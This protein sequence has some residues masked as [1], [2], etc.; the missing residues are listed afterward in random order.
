MESTNGQVNIDWLTAFKG[1]DGALI[2]LSEARRELRRARR[3]SHAGLAAERVAGAFARVRE[4]TNAARSAVESD[5]GPYSL[6]LLGFVALKRPAPPRKGASMREVRA[7]QIAAKNFD[8]R[9]PAR[10]TQEW[11]M[12]YL[13]LEARAAQ[14]LVEHVEHIG[15]S[16]VLEGK[17]QA[18]VIETKRRL[19]GLCCQVKIIESVRSPSESEVKRSSREPIAEAVRH[20]VWRRDDGRCVDCG[21]RERLEYDHIIPVSRGGSNTARNLEL[22]CESCNRSKGARI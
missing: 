7:Y 4:F 14:D 19:E 12:D 10:A 22:R 18:L 2:P 9:A 11:V 13:G 6:V 15:P 1:I 17:S 8:P 5:E 3:E 21:S 16:E 20:E